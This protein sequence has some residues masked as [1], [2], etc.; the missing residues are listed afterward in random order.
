M[1][2]KELIEKKL[3][4][5]Q[6][7]PAAKQALA[8]GLRDAFWRIRCWNCGTEQEVQLEHLGACKACNKPL[9]VRE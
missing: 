3:A 5:G 1:T 8:D 6:M 4:R 9:G 7:S 2:E